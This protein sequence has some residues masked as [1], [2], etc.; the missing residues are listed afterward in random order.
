MLDLLKAAID[1]DANSYEIADLADKLTAGQLL[2]GLN[3]AQLD[4]TTRALEHTITHL[5]YIQ[6]VHGGAC[7]HGGCD[8]CDL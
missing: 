5:E 6:R 4:A 7:P 2:E 8:S 1:N 3:P